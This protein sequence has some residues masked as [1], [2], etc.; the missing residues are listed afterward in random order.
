[1][2]VATSTTPATTEDMESYRRWMGEHRPVVE[3]EAAYL[4][5]GNDLLRLDHRKSDASSNSI[6]SGSSTSLM[7][8]IASATALPILLFH[9]LPGLASRLS[10]ILL[11]APSIA[12]VPKCLA[13]APLLGENESKQYL[14]VYFG[15]LM[16]AA[17][18]V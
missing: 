6:L 15:G 11:L 2:K 18:V 12:L 9:L 14:F 4:H 8:I 13:A 10:V 7:I 17:L 1:M 3:L 5:K 16:L